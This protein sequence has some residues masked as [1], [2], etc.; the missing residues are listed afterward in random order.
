MC[1]AGPGA[2]Q[3]KRKLRVQGAFFCSSPPP[4]RIEDMNVMCVCV[5]SSSFVV[6]GASVWELQGHT[7]AALR[8]GAPARPP[9]G[10]VLFL[11]NVMVPLV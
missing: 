2:R 1:V 7:Y 3:A 8:G 11:E 10:A 6:P 4:S 5:S 9:R